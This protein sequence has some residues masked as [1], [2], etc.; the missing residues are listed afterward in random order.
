MYAYVNTKK[1]ESNNVQWTI[2]GKDPMWILG[3]FDTAP[4]LD[5]SAPWSKDLMWVGIAVSFV[6]S[7]KS[8]DSS[9]SE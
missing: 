8:S 5:G 1:S 3:V 6:K 2:E 9:S 7:I 4:L